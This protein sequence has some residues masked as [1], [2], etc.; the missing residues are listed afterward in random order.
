M[1]T[2]NHINIE[3]EKHSP[4][5]YKNHG[6]FYPPYINSRISGQFSLFSIQPDPSK[7]FE[8]GF[9]DGFEN[10]II[11][12][13]FDQKTAQ[14]IQKRLFFLGIRH[15]TVF[16]DLEGFSFDR[17]VHLQFAQQHGH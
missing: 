10:W 17:K 6:I 9:F 5:N 1:H 4:N 12:I 2:C 11:K 3:G 8:D 16:P 13:N 14:E 7:S 15:E